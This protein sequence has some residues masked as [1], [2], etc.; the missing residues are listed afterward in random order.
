MDL[1]LLLLS[2][3]LF[4]LA[5]PSFVS[6]W[7][8][9]PLAFVALTPVFLVVHRAGWGATFAYGAF[10]GFASYALYN[11]WLGTFHPLTLFIV[12]PIYSVYL[13]AAFPLLKAADRLFPRWGFLLQTLI[14]VAYEYLKVQG[15][16]GYAYGIVGYSQYLFLPLIRI[17][18]L[19]G[20][21]AVSALV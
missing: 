2:A 13:L 16:L 17:A 3:L 6:T 20:V 14:W 15:F 21:W 19:T 5:F 10:F 12:P 7:G 18:S 8:W 9:F 1:G 11:Y 4:A